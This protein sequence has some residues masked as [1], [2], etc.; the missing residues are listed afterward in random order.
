MRF[1]N[2]KYEFAYY[3]K[4]LIENNLD[5]SPLMKVIEK[6]EPYEPDKSKKGYTCDCGNLVMRRE[7]FCP[8]CGQ[9][10]DWTEF[11][12]RKKKKNNGYINQQRRKGR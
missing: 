8:K 6:Q 1:K 4:L 3:L 12:K 10:L 5:R 9:K 11:D 7:Q 2:D